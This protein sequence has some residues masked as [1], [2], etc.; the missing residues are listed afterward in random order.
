MADASEPEVAALDAASSW[1]WPRYDDPRDTRWRNGE[2]FFGASPRP[3]YA[4]YHQDLP[5]NRIVGKCIR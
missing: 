2:P 1:W 5:T 4:S 3:G